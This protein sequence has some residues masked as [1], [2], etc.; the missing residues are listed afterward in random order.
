[1]TVAKKLTVVGAES[2]PQILRRNQKYKQEPQLC[3]AAPARQRWTRAGQRR[4]GSRRR[5][6]GRFQAGRENVVMRVAGSCGRR[7][8]QATF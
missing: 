6:I 1:M 8:R 3:A 7:E 2:N 4:L 5:S